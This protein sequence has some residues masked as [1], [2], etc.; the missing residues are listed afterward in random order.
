MRI[1]D[2]SS[3]VCSSD[4]CSTALHA[5][6]NAVAWL[7]AGLCTR[8]IAGGSEASLTPFTLAQ[9]KALKVY[10]SLDDPYPCRSMDPEK[11]RNTLILGEGAASFCL[12]A[13]TISE[14]SLVGKE[15]VSTGK[16]RWSP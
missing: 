4:L 10:S 15:C 8:F 12:E 7:R 3:D 2:W 11:M 14:E 13:E 6:I 9:M 16:Y 5:V 1:S